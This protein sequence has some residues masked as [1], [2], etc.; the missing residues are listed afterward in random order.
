MFIRRLPAIVG[1]NVFLRPLK[2]R[3][4]V[5]LVGW[6]GPVGVAAL[7]YAALAVR[8]TGRW[9]FW[10]VASLIVGVSLFAYGLTATPFTKYYG[11]TH[12][13]NT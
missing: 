6:F 13:E 1:V 7:Y 5:I 2:D 9:E 3:Q 4:Q 10:D 11:R 12:D 8:E